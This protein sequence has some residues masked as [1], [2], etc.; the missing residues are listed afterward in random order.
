MGRYYYGDIEGKFV[1]GLQ[2]SFAADQFGSEAVDESYEELDDDGD[3]CWVE[4]YSYY[5]C[6]DHLD[7]IKDGL[8]NLYTRM[9]PYKNTLKRAYHSSSIF[10]LT[11]EESRLYPLYADFRLGCQILECVERTGSCSFEVDA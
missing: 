11:D 10:Q 7:D 4:Q 3:T 1:F 5:F 2:S 8:T 6:E 9:T